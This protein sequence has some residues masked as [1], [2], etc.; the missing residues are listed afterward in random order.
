MSP[1]VKSLLTFCAVLATGVTQVFGVARGFACDCPGETRLVSSP[2][3]VASVCH[4]GYEHDDAQHHHDHEQEHD[5]GEHEGTPHEHRLV[6]ERP[7][8]STTVVVEL[9]PP[10]LCELVLPVLPGFGILLASEEAEHIA[11]PR[12]PD[13]TGGIPPAALLVADVIVIRV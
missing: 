1:F 4:P 13:D 9:A 12:P 3:C 7:T 6:T 10:V 5:G 11:R 2:V 8:V